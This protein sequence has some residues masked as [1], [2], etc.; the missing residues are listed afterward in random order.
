[1]PYTS[2]TYSIT[3]QGRSVTYYDDTGYTEVHVGGTRSW[4]NN[5]PGNLRYTNWTKNHGAIGKDG[6]G[7][8]IFPDVETGNQAKG[9]L[10]NKKWRG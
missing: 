5:N 4:R 1:M 3:K 10:C 8:A 7:F 9:D 2:A 6:D